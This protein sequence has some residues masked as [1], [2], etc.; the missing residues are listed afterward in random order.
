M[1]KGLAKSGDVMN[2]PEFTPIG[3]LLPLFT[4]LPNSE[5]GVSSARPLGL[6]RQ[7]WKKIAIQAGF[8]VLVSGRFT[9]HN[10]LWSFRRSKKAPTWG[11]IDVKSR[12]CCLDQGA[13]QQR[14]LF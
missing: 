2:L 12:C 3:N 1:M 8:R 5:I 6:R 10:A 7:A 13:V 4:A 11:V 9:N 14:F